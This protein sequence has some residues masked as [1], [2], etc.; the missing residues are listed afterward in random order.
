LLDEYLDKFMEQIKNK[1][2]KT[3]IVLVKGRYAY[4]Y[5]DDEHIIRYM[6]LQKFNYIDRENKHWKELT[7]YVQNKYNLETIDMTK[8]EYFAD[9]NYPFGFSPWHYENQYYQ[10]FIKELNGICLKDMLGDC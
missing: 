2:P 7:E 9:P 6:D 4:S 5:I 8:R 3:K 10:D 1:L